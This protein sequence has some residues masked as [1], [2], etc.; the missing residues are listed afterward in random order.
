V[1]WTFAYLFPEIIPSA[2]QFYISE[3]AR[4]KAVEV[5]FVSNYEQNHYKNTKNKKIKKIRIRN[6]LMLYM[7]KQ[8]KQK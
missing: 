6:L 8:K 3:T 5:R 1:F 7:P 2:L 4:G